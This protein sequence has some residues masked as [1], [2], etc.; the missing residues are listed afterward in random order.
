VGSPTAA[1]APQM[2][3]SVVRSAGRPPISTVVL[4]E[5]NTL[6]VGTWPGGGI[7]QTC[8]SVATAAGFYPI[9]TVA[10]HGPRIVPPWVLVSVT[11]AAAGIVVIPGFS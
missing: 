11:R 6:A 1:I 9:R 2:Q 10:T 4:P 5:G 7:E 8:W 3:V